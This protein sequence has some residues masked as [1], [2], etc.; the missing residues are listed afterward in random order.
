[1][2]SGQPQSA[3][4][5]SS[6]FQVSPGT[7]NTLATVGGSNTQQELATFTD[8]NSIAAGMSKVRVYHLSPDAGIAAVLANGQTIIPRIDY[9]QASD[10]LTVKPGVYNVDLVLQNGM[11]VQ[12]FSATLQG[13]KVA[14]VVAVGSAAQQGDG[15]LQFI[16]LVSDGV[17]TGMP[18][19]GAAP[20][21]RASAAT[22]YLWWA[23]LLAPFALAVR[24]PDLRRKVQGR[25]AA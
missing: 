4:I 1:M 10:Y 2:L 22:P 25:R 7:S 5:I 19:T 11:T 21:Q 17:P 3:T 15:K 6:S 12:P 8:D 20:V 18:P 13:N 16:T 23:A 14:S 24:L 9:K